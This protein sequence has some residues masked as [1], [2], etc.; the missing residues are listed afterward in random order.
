VRTW[1]LAKRPARSPSLAA[2]IWY[3]KML[4]LTAKRGCH[5]SVAQTPSEFV[6]SIEDPVMR[7]RVAQFTR[8][9]EHARFGNSAEDANCLPQLYEE[10][11][12]ANR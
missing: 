5:K 4:R 6:I 8:R 3:E 12:S 10:V 9:Y 7:E 2:T 11:S 1:R